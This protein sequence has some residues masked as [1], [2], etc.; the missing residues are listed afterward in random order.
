LSPTGTPTYIHIGPEGEVNAEFEGTVT[1]TG[2]IL[3]A[4]VEFEKPKEKNEIV[5][6]DEEGKGTIRG[7]LYV[8]RENAIE[9]ILVAQTDPPAG[10]QGS[11][12]LKANSA[13]DKA[14][15]QATA[16]RAGQSAEITEAKATAGAYGVVIINGN[17]AS[18]F[19]KNVAFTANLQLQVIKFNFGFIG[20]AGASNIALP[21]AFPTEHYADLV[22]HNGFQAQVLTAKPVNLSESEISWREAGGIQGAL[23]ALGH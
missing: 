6:K 22:T 5:W 3:P 14:T 15:L 7:E 21:T 2:L 11:I 20:G 10:E 13:I 8:V 9:C 12:L 4:G 19:V 1:A 16:R 23:L 17:N 18:S